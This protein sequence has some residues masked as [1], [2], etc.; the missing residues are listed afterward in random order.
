MGQ[1]VR[2]LNTLYLRVN[3]TKLNVKKEDVVCSHEFILQKCTA[4]NGR[5]GVTVILVFDYEVAF[6][7]YC[8]TADWR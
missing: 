6:L 4:N 5:W 2:E 1:S 3:G 7:Q 8:C